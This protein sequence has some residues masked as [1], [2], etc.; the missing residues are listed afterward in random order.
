MSLSYSGPLPPETPTDQPSPPTPSPGPMATSEAAM[1]EFIQGIYNPFLE[2][3]AAAAA[4]T[5]RMVL[6]ARIGPAG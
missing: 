4:S 1:N 2:V 6:P 3:G 5:A